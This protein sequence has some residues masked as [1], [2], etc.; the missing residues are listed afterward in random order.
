ML[1]AC[2]EALRRDIW[3]PKGALTPS[4][5]QGCQRILKSRRASKQTASLGVFRRIQRLFTKH[6]LSD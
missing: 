3:S 6:P 5:A 1:C 4:G 2:V